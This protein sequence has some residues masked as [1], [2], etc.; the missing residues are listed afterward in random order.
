MKNI[1]REEA[2]YLRKHGGD[3]YVKTIGKQAKARKKSFCVIE[4]NGAMRILKQY[5]TK[6]CHI[7]Y[8]SAEKIEGTNV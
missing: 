4:A 7:V 5:W 2:K 8:D 1:S 3:K 6:E